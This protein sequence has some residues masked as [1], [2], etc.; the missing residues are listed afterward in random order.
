MTFQSIRYRTGFSFR[1]ATGHIDEVLNRIIE[2]GAKVAPITDRSSTFGFN[3][4]SKACKK[5]GI[6]PVYGI[7][8]AV[9]VDPVA[10][11]PV[12]DYWT[13]ISYSDIKEINR[14]LAVAT[15]QFRYTNVLSYEQAL[16]ADCFKIVGHRSDVARIV[17]ASG[18]KGPLN[19]YY[20]LGPAVS[21]GYVAQMREAGINPAA[22][23]DNIYPTKRRE[24]QAEIILGRGFSSQSYPQ[25]ILSEDEWLDSIAHLDMSAEEIAAAIYNTE[26]I[27]EHSTSH[28]VLSEFMIPEKPETLRAMCERGA[29]KLGVDLTNEVY[30]ERLDRELMLI[31]VKGYDNYFYIVADLVSWARERMLVGPARGSSCGSLVCYLLGITMVD[32]IPY[33]LLFERF[34]DIN[35]MDM[36]DIDIDFADQKR[37]LVEEYAADKYG[38]DHVARLGTVNMFKARSALQTTCMELNV[39]RWKADKALDALVKRS[40]A[41]ARAMD[42]LIDTL[43]LTDAG[44][45]LVSEHP[46]IVPVLEGFE[47]HPRHAGQHAAGIV[48][49]KTPIRDT[50]A[51]DS[52][53]GA[54]QCDKKDAE[55]LNLL[56]IDALGLVQL[57][58]FEDCLAL[59][60]LPKKHLDTISYDDPA[61]YAVLNNSQFAGIFQYNGKALQY[62][63]NYIKSDNLED[64][65]S[66]TALARPG[67]LASGGANEWARRRIGADPV[68]YPHP[69]FESHLKNSLGVIIY[70]EQVMTIGRDIGDMNWEEVTQV[71][72]AMAKSMGKEYFNQF[73]DKWKIGAM[74]KG[75]S[76]EVADTVWDQLCAYGAWSF[77]RSHS[78]AYGM[79]SYQC[80]W[81]KAH[82]PLEFAAAT[83]QHAHDTE[84]QLKLLREIVSEGHN[85]IPV[86][87]E[88]ST[89]RWTVGV[90]GPN[91]MRVL[92]GPLQNVKGIG[93]K[94]VVKVI[95]ARASG[96]K[97][98]GREAKLL[99]NPVTP[100]D[101]LF[102]IRDAFRKYLPDPKARN[103]FTEPTKIIDIQCV[104]KNKAD[105]EHLVFCVL[106]RIAPRDEND[107]QNVA[108]RGYELRG[109][110]QALNLR[111]MDDTD[112]L[113]AKINRMDYERIGAEIVE[114]GVP[115][116]HLYVLKGTVRSGLDFRMFNVK[117]AR[118]ICPIGGVEEPKPVKVKKTKQ[119]DD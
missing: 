51:I 115:L 49:S 112:V 96:K 57:S 19:T 101:S 99:E 36:P 23:G 65:I 59:A 13:F 15:A 72:K 75:I 98:T 102:P 6:R 103:I 30:K 68:T 105:E 42:T 43:S 93:P 78:V 104:P 38:I 86:D 87:A 92:V 91:K 85:Y 113:F 37:H 95:S 35:R 81:L 97:L 48:I 21:R 40:S 106:A 16:E 58:I 29:A 64:I 116:K 84:L 27:L 17:T 60:G 114:R 46:E 117:A 4:W 47:G 20:A 3:K 14:L 107:L 118:Y 56:K 119:Q 39:P 80:C 7:E 74:K 69:V 63:A 83:L 25:H 41:D 53:T 45:E 55:E 18:P 109:P 71:R 73:G 61:A 28:M 77:N 22:S 1:A 79:I 88:Q 26:D 11:K 12:I 110:T 5:K 8:L 10:K 54:T 100:L 44:K 62:L 31:D 108:K 2:T 32:P 89:N 67:P 94:G 52:R 9:S 111:I 34:V 33:G 76:K 90:R 50:V 24:A 82:Y 66:V 70:Q